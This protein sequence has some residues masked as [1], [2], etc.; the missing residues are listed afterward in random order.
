MNGALSHRSRRS[1]IMSRKL[2]QK[3]TALHDLLVVEPDVEVAADAIDV[4]FRD[5]IR[6][7]VLGIGMPKGDV[8]AGNFF[9]LQNV[10]DHVGA[11]GVG[12]YGELADAVAVLIRVRVSAKFFQQLFVRALEITDAVLFD[13]N[14]QRRGLKIAVLLTEVIAHY[15]V[16]DEDAA[17]VRR[18]CKNFAPGQVAPFIRRDN[19]TGLE[20][21]ERR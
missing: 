10:A 15:T 5:P 16:H 4:R 14:S 19:A 7:G 1:A 8:D 3:L 18:R 20:P 13:L 6:S 9:V 17:R 12:A 11:G 2:H 21:L